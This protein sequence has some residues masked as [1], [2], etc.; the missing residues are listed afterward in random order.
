MRFEVCILGSNAATFAFGR[1]VTSQVLNIR[2]HLFMIDCGEGT[3]IRLQEERIKAARIQQI[4]I[5]HMHGDHIYGLIGLINSFSLMG[6]QAPLC[7]YGPKDLE[8]FINI[9]LR[10]TES[11]LTYKLSFFSTQTEN[12]ELIFE[13]NVLTVHSFPLKHK[14]PTTGF[15]FKEKEGLR[16]LISKQLVHYNIPKEY[17]NILKTGVDYIIPETGEIIKNEALTLAPAT[18]RAYAFCSDTAY[19]PSIVNYIQNV[20]LLYHEATFMA[21]Q[22]EKAA[23][24]FHSTS[25]DAANI[26]LAAK[27]KSLLI[28]HFSSRYEDL[29][30]LLAEAQKIFPNTALALEGRFFSIPFDAVKE[31][32]V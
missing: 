8:E 19:D 18:P 4:F 10:L 6:R 20:D 14:I 30:P 1:H 28:G 2:E 22:A 23:I 21:D 26:A 7:I 32:Q 3:Q 12:T 29:A 16:R 11:Y 25:I 13:N 15:I 24:N 27:A 5:S 17:F 31:E 9:Q